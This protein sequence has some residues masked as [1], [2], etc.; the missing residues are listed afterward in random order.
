MVLNDGVI[1]K[2][3]DLEATVLLFGVSGT[4]VISFESRHSH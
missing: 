1:L 2:N 4:V 3:N